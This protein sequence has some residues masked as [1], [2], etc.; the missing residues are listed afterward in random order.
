MS[1]PYSR[2]ALTPDLM[3]SGSPR[4]ERSA[5]SFARKLWRRGRERTRDSWSASDLSRRRRRSRERTSA[6]IQFRS[7]LDAKKSSANAFLGSRGLTPSRGASFS[8][9][10]ASG[11]KTHRPAIFRPPRRPLAASARTRDSCTQSSRA[12]A[13]DERKRR[14]SICVNYSAIAIVVST[15]ARTALADLEL[16]GRHADVDF[17]APIDHPHRIRIHREH[18]GQC[19]H[20]AA[21]EV[22]S[23]PVAWTFDQAV[24]ELALSERSAIVRADI[25]DRAPRAVVAMAKAQAL[26]AGVHHADL[27]LRHILFARDRDELAQTRTPISAM[28][29]IRG[30]T[31]FNTRWRTCSSFSSLITRR[32][33][34][35]T[36][37][38]CAASRSNPRD[39]A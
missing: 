38:C 30:R 34:P 26:L 6:R 4:I 35:C 10:K 17:D 18:R 7:S 13:E 37:S 12:T 9:T 16:P 25:V 28:L 3:K 2:A 14:S 39:I 19:A 33:K 29:P 5:A 23:R 11:S 24:I 20:V 36:R 31:A 22:E 27:A 21:E 32:K 8:S 1:T 15:P